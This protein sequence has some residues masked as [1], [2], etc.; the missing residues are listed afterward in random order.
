MKWILI[1]VGVL[2]ILGGAGLF[3]A[4]TY[5]ENIIEKAVRYETGLDVRIGDVDIGILDPGITIRNL[6]VFNPQG[7]PA[8]PFVALPLISARVVPSSIFSDTV[9]MREVRIHLSQASI[10][11]NAQGKLNATVISE[12]FSTPSDPST[13]GAADSKTKKI[14]IDRLLLSLGSIRYF[15]EKTDNPLVS[16]DVNIQDKE[17]RNVSD[18]KSVIRAVTQEVLQ[19]ALGI[20]IV[21]TAISASLGILTGTSDAT[22]ET[23]KATIHTA[24]TAVKKLGEGLKKL[25]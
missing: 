9:R 4:T 18:L 17:F 5:I 14:H 25:F 8:Q 13:A 19:G 10:Y 1:A 24:K 21:K 6:V 23:G 7:F 20:G 12:M 15:G 11:K 2:V 3:A 16:L 22:L